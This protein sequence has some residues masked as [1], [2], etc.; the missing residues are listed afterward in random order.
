MSGTTFELLA[1]S[2]RRR[3]LDLMLQ[4][5]CDVGTLVSRMQMS[6]PAISKQLRILR[7]AG[8]AEVRVDAQRRLYRLRPEGLREVDRWLAPYRAQW[9]GSVEHQQVATSRSKRGKWRPRETWRSDRDK[10]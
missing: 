1:D 5:E 8:L 2:T 10:F 3:L 4:G 9:Q 7:K 6:Q